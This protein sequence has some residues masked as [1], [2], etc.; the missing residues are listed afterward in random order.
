L[1]Q[2]PFGLAEGGRCAIVR[3]KR[4]GSRIA[5]V[6]AMNQ[7]ESLKPGRS[8][9]VPELEGGQEFICQSCGVPI[10]RGEDHGTSAKGTRVD[11]YCSHC[12]RDGH[13]TEPNLKKDD[14]IARATHY[15]TSKARMPETKAL[16]LANQIVPALKRWTNGIAH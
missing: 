11:D 6:D 8:R 16:L 15:L 13:F 7:D 5:F 2:V 10:R 12:Y 9:P 14:M 4:V 1:S 3:K